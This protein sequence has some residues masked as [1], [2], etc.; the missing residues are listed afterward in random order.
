ML[1][2]QRVVVAPRHHQRL[3][4]KHLDSPHSHI[5][6]GFST[7]KA[8]LGKTQALHV[9]AALLKSPDGCLVR[10]LENEGLLYKHQVEFVQKVEAGHLL[11][12]AETPP[13]N[14]NQVIAQITHCLNELRSSLGSEK[15]LEHSRQHACAILA[16][17]VA[18][19]VS[20]AHA[21]IDTTLAGL[22]PE[23]ALE[24]PRM[25]LSITKRELAATVRHVLAPERE[26]IVVVGPADDIP[27]NS[28]DPLHVDQ[29][30][31]AETRP[32]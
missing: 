21:L 29:N 5:I 30:S 2:R 14:Q 13:A 26:V 10:L 8:D 23:T 22:P 7:P 25:P 27:D 1:Q 4:R 3:L 20:L 32:P 24:A 28:A 6:F 12:Y 18:N 11:L 31:H 15:E 17:K 16:H 19:P 9:I